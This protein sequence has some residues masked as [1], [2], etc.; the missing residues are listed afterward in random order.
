MAHALF[1]SFIGPGGLGQAEAMVACFRV[2]VYGAFL[3][4]GTSAGVNV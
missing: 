2:S 1:E 3:S 4:N